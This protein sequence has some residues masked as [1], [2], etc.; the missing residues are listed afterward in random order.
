MTTLEQRFSYLPSEILPTMLV[1][2]SFMST[3]FMKDFSE[4]QPFHD[5]YVFSIF[6][7]KSESIWYFYQHLDNNLPATQFPSS[8]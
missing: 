1:I 3:P 4:S 2:H 6:P 7:K 5:T 8:S